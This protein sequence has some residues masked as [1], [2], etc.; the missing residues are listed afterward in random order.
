MMM[1][2]DRW[3]GA[4]VLLLTAAAADTRR[5]DGCEAPSAGAYPPPAR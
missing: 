3:C 4:L 1:Q 5:T 2:R